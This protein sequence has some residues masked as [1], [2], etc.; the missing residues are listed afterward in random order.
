[1][2]TWS[3]YALDVLTSNPIEGSGMLDPHTGEYV[4]GPTPDPAYYLWRKDECSTHHVHVTTFHRFTNR[5]VLA[6]ERDVARFHRPKDLW[7]L[8]QEHDTERRMRRHISQRQR[9]E[10]KVEAN[11]RRIDDLVLGNKLGN[12]QAKM[13]SYGGQINRS[14]PGDV[15][16]D[17]KEDGWE[18]PEE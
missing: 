10:D 6:L 15:E 9:Q 7:R 5:E 16:V 12:R 17:A 11:E 4:T 3:P 8:F 13:F 2:V 1:V 18:L 14:T